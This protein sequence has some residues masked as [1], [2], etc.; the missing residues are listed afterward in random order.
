MQGLWAVNSQRIA[1]L[2]E[3]GLVET[4]PYTTNAVIPA[5]TLYFCFDVDGGGDERLLKKRV[6]APG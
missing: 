5:Y 4:I 2:P 6:P 1:D 3:T